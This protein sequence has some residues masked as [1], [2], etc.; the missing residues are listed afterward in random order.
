MNVRY[1]FAPQQ[2]NTGLPAE[3]EGAKETFFSAQL[4]VS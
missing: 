1:L 2:I 3:P 4:R